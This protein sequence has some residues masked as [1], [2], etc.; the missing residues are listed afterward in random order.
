MAIEICEEEYGSEYAEMLKEIIK[1]LRLNDTY[2]YLMESYWCEGPE[3][4][5]IEIWDKFWLEYR[6]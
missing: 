1:E 3:V 4:E 5:V 6:G 2:Y